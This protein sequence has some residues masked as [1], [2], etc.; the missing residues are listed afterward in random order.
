MRYSYDA[1]V[2]KGETSIREYN[3]VRNQKGM[4]HEL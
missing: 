3:Q 2:S 1:R 4:K